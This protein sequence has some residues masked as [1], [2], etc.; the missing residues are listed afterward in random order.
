MQLLGSLVPKFEELQEQGEQGQKVLAQ[1]T[2]W[3]SVPLAFVQGIGIVFLINQILGGGVI[4]T[5]N[6]TVL[7]LSAFA[8]T[9]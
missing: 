9:I 2:R 4:D 5:S 6:L 8:L 7:L 3:L 1:Y